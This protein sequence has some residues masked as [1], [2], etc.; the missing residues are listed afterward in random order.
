MLLKSSPLISVPIDTAA[1]SL[2]A[3]SVSSSRKVEKSV[4]AAFSRVPMA[5]TTLEY[6]H[7]GVTIIQKMAQGK[8]RRSLL[9][10]VIQNLGQFWEV[11]TVPLLDT[12]GVCVQLLHK[13]NLVRQHRNEL[14]HLVNVIQQADTLNNHGINFFRGKLQAVAGKRV[15]EAEAHGTQVLLGK[16]GN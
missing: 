11:P 8:W 13:I 10:V 1:V 12:H 6:L 5:K 4:A 2:S 14:S 9:N 7:D 3:C 15:A 16:A